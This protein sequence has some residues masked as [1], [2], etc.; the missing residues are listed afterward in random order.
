MSFLVFQAVQGRIT[1]KFMTGI[2]HLLLNIF[3]SSSFVLSPLWSFSLL[4]VTLVPPFSTG[5]IH[6]PVI[7]RPSRLVISILFLRRLPQQDFALASICRTSCN[8][9]IT[10]SS[11]LHNTQ[12]R[13]ST[14]FHP[15]PQCWCK[16]IGHDCP[17]YVSLLLPTDAWWMY[18]AEMYKMSFFLAGESTKMPLR[19]KRFFQVSSNI[20]RNNGNVVWDFDF[21]M[22]EGRW[23]NEFMESWRWLQ[24]GALGWESSTSSNQSRFRNYFSAHEFYT[25]KRFQ[26]EEDRG[27][28][29]PISLRL[30][31]E[32]AQSTTSS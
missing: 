25:S 2:I 17:L 10:F 8:F 21:P 18:I 22:G 12:I 9:F 29:K 7:F 6:A 14:S 11:V 20:L 16:W 5:S 4:P 24:R 32:S 1:L 27:N 26:F 23:R 30:F 13:R 31:C 15:M 19:H 3:V 28:S